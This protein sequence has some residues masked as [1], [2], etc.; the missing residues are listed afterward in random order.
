M[1]KYFIGTDVSKLKLDFC[2]YI[3]GEAIIEEVVSNHSEAIKA[4]L[5]DMEIERFEIVVCAEHTGQYTYPLACACYDL[6]IDLWLENAAQIKMSSGIHRGKDDKVDA[7]RI[8]E[9]ASRFI[10]RAKYYSFPDKA[11]MSLKQLVSER[12]MY[13]CDR[14]KYQAQL[15]DQKDYMSPNDY[16]KKSRRLTKLVKNLDL[17]I[18]QVE[19]EIN[20]LIDNDETLSRQHSLL[21]SIDGIGERTSIK[22][23]ITTNAFRDYDNHK[24]FCCQAGVAPF[25]YTSG[26]SQRSKNKVS[27]R[28]DKSIK[29]LLHMSALSAIRTKGELRNYYESKVEEGKNKMS[30]INAVRAKLIARMF[31]VIRDNREYEKNYINPLA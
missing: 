12:D 24:K 29:A 1:K 10:D 5:K 18:E 23:I 19:A 30:V 22:M 26:T 13:V 25:S 17:S 8:A 21:C 3:D 31:A 16:R 28:A 7:Y 15:S 4:F 2:V 27:N 6:D 9:Y 11:I 14:A 20:M